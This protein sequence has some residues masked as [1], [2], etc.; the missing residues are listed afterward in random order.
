M[1]CIWQSVYRLHVYYTYSAIYVYIPPCMCV[2]QCTWQ[3]Y[4]YVHMHIYSVYGSLCTHIRLETTM[5][6]SYVYTTASSVYMAVC[7]ITHDRV[8]A[9]VSHVVK[10]LIGTYGRVRDSVICVYDCVICVYGSLPSLMAES[11]TLPYVS[12]RTHTTFIM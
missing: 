10:L 6:L 3:H 9:H 2:W 12:I 7:H 11:W 5:T 1:Q 4:A 8:M